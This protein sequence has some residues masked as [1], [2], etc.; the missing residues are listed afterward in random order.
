MYQ[1]GKQEEW[2]CPELE[3]EL[4]GH[5]KGGLENSEPGAAGRHRGRWLAFDGTCHLQRS[6]V[7]E[8]A[9]IID[10]PDRSAAEPQPIWL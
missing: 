9:A 2:D 4:T 8:A 6:L 5:G 1:E 7:W 3:T 10:Y